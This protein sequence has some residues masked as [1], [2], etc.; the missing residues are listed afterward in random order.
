MA[1][2]L[3]ESEP[4]TTLDLTTRFLKPVWNARLRAVALL[5]SDGYNKIQDRSGHLENGR[6]R[7]WI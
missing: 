3:E 1:T 4:F 2:A 6:D 7:S 5:D